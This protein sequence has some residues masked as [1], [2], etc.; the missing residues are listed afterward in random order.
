MN[1][2]ILGYSYSSQSI[3]ILPEAPII[4]M[5][6]YRVEPQDKFSSVPGG[7]QDNPYIH[8]G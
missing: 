6:R 1:R 5:V 8:T 4:T 3:P 7:Q 2:R